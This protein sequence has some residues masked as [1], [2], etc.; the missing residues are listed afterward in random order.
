M[1]PTLRTALGALPK[2][3][4]FVCQ[5]AIHTVSQMLGILG[6][7]LLEDHA[8][9]ERDGS[10]LVG[11]PRDRLPLLLVRLRCVD[12]ARPSDRLRDGVPVCDACARKA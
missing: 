11:E 10:I 12:C 2:D 5:G 6:Q 9:I 4:P 7:G 8:V 3:R 1:P